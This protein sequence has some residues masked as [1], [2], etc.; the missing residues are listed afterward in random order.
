MLIAFCLDDERKQF[1]QIVKENT[2]III[3][4]VWHTN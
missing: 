2:I 3:S 1:L 4:F